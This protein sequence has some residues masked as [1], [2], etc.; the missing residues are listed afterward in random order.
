M[1]KFFKQLF[2]NHSYVELDQIFVTDRNLVCINPF[3]CV[4]CA[5]VKIEFCFNDDTERKFYIS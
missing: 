2:C 3:I 4:H 5:K 1:F